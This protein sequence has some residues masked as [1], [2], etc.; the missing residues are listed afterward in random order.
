MAK[1][2]LTILFLW[3]LVLLFNSPI[4]GEVLEKD[5][6]FPEEIQQ[7]QPQNLQKNKSRV[8]A[9]RLNRSPSETTPQ[10]QIPEALQCCFPPKP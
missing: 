8:N 5:W 10:T 3:L 1:Y 9:L 7:T 6:K 2:L 4:P